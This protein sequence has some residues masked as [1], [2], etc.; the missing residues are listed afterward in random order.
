MHCAHLFI[1]IGTPWLTISVIIE[2]EGVGSSPRSFPIILGSR[3]SHRRAYFPITVS[4]VVQDI[5]TKTEVDIDPP[6]INKARPL[7]HSS[8]P[9][10]RARHDQVLRSPTVPSCLNDYSQVNANAR[11]RNERCSYFD[12]SSTANPFDSSLCQWE[13][14]HD[15]GEIN[16]SCRPRTP[17]HPRDR[18]SLSGEDAFEKLG[19]NRCIIA[20]LIHQYYGER[21]ILLRKNRSD[22]WELPR[23]RELSEGLLHRTLTIA[24]VDHPW[25]TDETWLEVQLVLIEECPSSIVAA[26]HWFL[27]ASFSTLTSLDPFDANLIKL[28]LFKWCTS[29]DVDESEA[30]NRRPQASSSISPLLLLRS[31]SIFKIQ[32]SLSRS[33]TY[34]M[35]GTS[36]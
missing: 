5:T 12:V 26:P 4:Q 19:A 34:R 36:Q 17:Q 11:K 9:K 24:H 32:F 7:L 1:S 6:R 16:F 22:R 15:H 33:F 31:W 3:F 23:I 35:F 8:S 13:L 2:K 30:N 20:L 21:Y 25:N 28:Y 14:I 29:A 10:Q 18:L 27:L